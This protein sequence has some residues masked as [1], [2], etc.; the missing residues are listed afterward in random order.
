MI[1]DKIW[2]F[3]GWLFIGLFVTV[4]FGWIAGLTAGI[5]IGVLKECWDKYRGG[6]FDLWDLG[7][8]VLGTVLGVWI[9]TKFG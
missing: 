6:K 4:I 8:D 1:T 9:V 5:T 3:L 2:H 7:A